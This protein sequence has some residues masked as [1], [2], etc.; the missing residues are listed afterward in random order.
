MMV[1]TRGAVESL[2][3]EQADI[4]VIIMDISLYYY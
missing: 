2:K 3:R 4:K 1:M